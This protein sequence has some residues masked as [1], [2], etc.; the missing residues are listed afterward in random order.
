MTETPDGRA[1]FT[2]EAIGSG[3]KV[4]LSAPGRSVLLICFAQETQDGIEEVEAA[5]RRRFATADEL[6][7]GHVI[8]LHK[9]PGLLRKVAE[10]VLAG[11][12]RK[13]VEA[14]PA[15]QEPDDYVVILPDWDGAGVRRLGLEDA[16]QALGLA[17]LRADG[18]I[19]WRYQGPDP[20]A[21]LAA[22]L[23]SPV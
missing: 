18:S 4:D 6:L 15:G 10:G 13:A 20:A 2:L 22:R 23:A 1:S 5:A 17:L 8:D 16:T 3:R 12:H 9:V 7:V 19:A 14:L 11:E 21:A